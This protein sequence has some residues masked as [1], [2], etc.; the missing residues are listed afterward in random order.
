MT[1]PDLLD[2]AFAIIK[3][4]P[5]D[6]LVLAA[7]FVVP[8]QLLSS[9]LLRDVLSAS[10]F[11]GTGIGDPTSSVGVEESGELT[12]VGSTVVS[13]LI[14]ISS[15]ALLAGALAL[16]V[17][18]WYQGR[19]EPPVRTVVRTLKRA[20][21]LVVGVVVVHVLEAVGLIGLGIGAYVMMGLLHVVSPVITAEGVGPF[22]AIGRSMRLTSARFWRSMGIPAL[23][24]MIG[25]LLGI[26]F[27]LIPE[28]ATLFV[29]DDWNWL[30]RSAGSMLSQLIV[31]PFT[32]GVAVLYHLDLRMRTEG[33]DVAL[34][35]AAL[36]EGR[37]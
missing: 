25:A 2:G 26:G 22:R 33:Y 32:A 9:I 17:A 15:L 3:L 5:R 29:S 18:D 19:R 8:I 14:G 20:P 21:A 36:E 23:V 10:G 12:G 24:G 7:A 27:Q 30:V 13:L 11:G 16:L 4:R 37:R 34:T 31:A 6:V 35:V 1:V 28:V